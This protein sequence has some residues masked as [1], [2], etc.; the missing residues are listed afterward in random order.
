MEYEQIMGDD[1]PVEGRSVASDFKRM[2]ESMPRNGRDGFRFGSGEC[3]D[4]MSGADRAAVDQITC[5]LKAG[6]VRRNRKLKGRVVIEF[7]G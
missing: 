5:E 6:G 2:K 4:G 7:N 3:D 1:V